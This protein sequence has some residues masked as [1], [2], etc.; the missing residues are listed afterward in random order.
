MIRVIALTVVLML[1]GTPVATAACLLWCGMPCQSDVPPT[2]TTAPA[3][4]AGCGSALIIPP[5]LRE[6]I[7]RAQPSAVVAQPLDVAGHALALDWSHDRL[8]SNLLHAH[9]P[10]VYC[11][12]VSV[13]RI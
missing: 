8:S 10:P 4:G 2:G 13:L 12:P 7:L 9:A 6:E 11:R 1:T 3:G 5:V